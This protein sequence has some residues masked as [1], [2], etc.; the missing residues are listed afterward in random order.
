MILFPPPGTKMTK[1]GALWWIGPLKIQI[2]T[3][4]WHFF[5]WMLLRPANI[6][7]FKL[8]DKTQMSKPPECAT[9]FFRNLRSILVGN[10]GLQS[11]SL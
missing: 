10:F 8:M 9:T 2:F 5:C 1:N 7:F 11:L 6:T 3:D 4:I